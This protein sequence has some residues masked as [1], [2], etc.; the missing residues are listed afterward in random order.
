MRLQ[1]RKVEVEPDFAILEDRPAQR[2]LPHLDLAPILGK[3]T[4]S[5]PL[6]RNS[7]LPFA[8]MSTSTTTRP[9]KGTI[10]HLLSARRRS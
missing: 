3:I 1:D 6:G 2:H 9:T 5:L 4:E 8:S 7:R 10:L